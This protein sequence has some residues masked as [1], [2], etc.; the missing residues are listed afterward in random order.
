MIA[1]VTMLIDHVAAVV[2]LYMTSYYRGLEEFANADTVYYVMRQIGRTAF[3]IFC[4]L[5][6]EG[7]V[8]T[9]NQF[10]YLTRLLMFAVVSEVPFDLAVSREPIAWGNQNVFFTLALGMLLMIMMEH[11]SLHI[12]NFLSEKGISRGKAYVCEQL[13][14]IAILVFVMFV[15]ELIRCDYDYR[16]ILL[17]AIFYLLKESRLLACVIGY[18]SF[19]WEPFC[20]PAFLLIPLYNEKRGWSLKYIFYVFYP[21]HLLCL[22]V[23]QSVYLS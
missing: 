17:I 5:L 9:K 23:L 1:M 22:Y 13:Y 20:F 6:V 7:F 8:H 12:R 10:R 4:F 11:G 19:M 3:P 16:G 21:L 2:L 18:L 15:A 14:R